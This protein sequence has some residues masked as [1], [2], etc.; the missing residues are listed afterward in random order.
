MMGEGEEE[1]EEEET[2][3]KEAPPVFF[4]PFTFFSSQ[5]A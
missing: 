1:E 2:R 4:L 3:F 5:S